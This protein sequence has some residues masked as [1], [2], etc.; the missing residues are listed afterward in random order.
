M[1]DTL[2]SPLHEVADAF[3]AN[4]LFQRN[5]WTDGLPIVPP[6]EGGVRRFLE[7]AGLP[8]DSVV[9]VEPVR[10]GLPDV[11]R[12]V[13]ARAVRVEQVDRR[14]GHAPRF[15]ERRDDPRHHVRDVDHA[16]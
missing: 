3:E 7:T 14:V 2:R 16:G 13:E 8:A 10:R 11:A 1:T 6:T 5:G 12:T 9:G 15:L 4:E